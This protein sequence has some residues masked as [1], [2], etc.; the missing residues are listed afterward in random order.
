MILLI[1]PV[2][3]FCDGWNSE[4]KR[5]CFS[6]LLHEGQNSCFELG[7]HTETGLTDIPLQLFK[8]IYYNEPCGF[9]KTLIPDCYCVSN[10]GLYQIREEIYLK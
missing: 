3:I 1:F 5:L 8:D 10:T 7:K 9:P 2:R 4:W 6:F